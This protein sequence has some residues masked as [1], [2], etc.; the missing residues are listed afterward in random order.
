MDIKAFKDGFK[1]FETADLFNF[2]RI[3]RTLMFWIQ[4][5]VDIKFFKIH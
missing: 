1:P 3:N 5:F 4:D 2:K